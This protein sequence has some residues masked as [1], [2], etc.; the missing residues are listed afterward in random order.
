MKY[1]HLPF[2]LVLLIF[3][4][5]NGFC[6]GQLEVYDS[7]FPDGDNSYFGSM[8][9]DHQNNL[10][11]VTS[12][13]LWRLDSDRTNPIR[14]VDE[15]IICNVEVSSDGSVWALSDNWLYR[16]TESATV[17]TIACPP[18]LFLALDAQDTLWLVT[19]SHEILQRNGTE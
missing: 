18:S 4:A 6:Q 8:T 14:V 17:D 3:S 10:W 13:S 9:V 15:H 7:L 16:I 11:I 12:H 1:I 19:K 5:I 2:C